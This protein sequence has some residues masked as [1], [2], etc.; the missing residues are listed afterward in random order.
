MDTLF[1]LLSNSNFKVANDT[2]ELLTI[3]PPN[4][5]IRT[6]FEKLSIESEVNCLAIYELT[7]Y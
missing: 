7:F 2:W 1:E 6:A 4:K 5:N 3:L